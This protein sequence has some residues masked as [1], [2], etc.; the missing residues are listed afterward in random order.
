MT[1]I[2]PLLVP[3]SRWQPLLLLPMLLFLAGCQSTPK[4]SHQAAV[5]YPG[6]ME[7]THPLALLYQQHADWH[8]T[9]YRLGGTSR[10]GIDCSA[11][12]QITYRDLFGI[13][14]PRTAREQVSVGQRVSRR[15]LQTGDLVFFRRGGHVGIYLQNDQFLHASTSQGVKIS[16]MNNQYWSRHY[17][18]AISV[19]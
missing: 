18:R 14:L 8:G 17:W 9:P 1:A 15:S 12:V 11:F 13:D 3:L 19:K 5:V 6:A 7:D 10:N 4:P 16:N 2:T